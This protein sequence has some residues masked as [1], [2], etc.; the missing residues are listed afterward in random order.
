MMSP[1]GSISLSLSEVWPHL[2][3]KPAISSS[4]VL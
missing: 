3:L 2:A 1:G 4:G